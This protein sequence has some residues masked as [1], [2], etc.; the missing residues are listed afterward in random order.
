MFK[1]KKNILASK[2]FEE[3]N[4]KIQNRTFPWFAQNYVNSSDESG[5]GYFTHYLFLDEKINSPFY[6]L[7]M[8]PFNKIF[9]DKKL[10]RARLNLYTKTP[11][12][13]KHGY[14]VDYMFKH[15]SIVYFLNDN[16]GF[17]YFKNPY[18]KIKPEKNK[19]VIFDGDYEHASSSCTDKPFRI[20]LNINYEF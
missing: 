10:L 20:T 5:Y 18:K 19:G 9:N 14:H 2:V 3:I 8:K 13:I 7:I 1:I 17:L 11:K 4:V 16:N 15:K 12:S 6:D